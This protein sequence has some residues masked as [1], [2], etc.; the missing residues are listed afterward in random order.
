MSW[1]GQGVSISHVQVSLRNI[2]AQGQAYVAL[3]RATSLSGLVVEGVPPNSDRAAIAKCFATNRDVVEYYQ[4]LSQEPVPPAT[5]QVQQCAADT[6][7][8]ASQNGSNAIQ[9]SS[10][11]FA[12][13]PDAPSRA[14]TQTLSVPFAPS[15]SRNMHAVTVRPRSNACFNLLSRNKL[16]QCANSSHLHRPKCI[17]N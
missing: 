8:L 12:Y 17:R 7:Q 2:F 10:Q 13:C 9:S 6:P 14:C 15:S 4:S 11:Q 5:A 3:S 1:T 16:L